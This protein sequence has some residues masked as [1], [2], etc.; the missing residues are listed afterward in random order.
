MRSCSSGHPIVS[1][2]QLFYSNEPNSLGAYPSQ[3]VAILRCNIGYTIHGR[4]G[5]EFNLEIDL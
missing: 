1:N 5:M 3:T 4:F 2:G